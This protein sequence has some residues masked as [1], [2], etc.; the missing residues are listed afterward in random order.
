MVNPLLLLFALAN[1]GAPASPYGSVIVA[2]AR[3]LAL[4]RFVLM[5]Q[6]SILVILPAPPR[7]TPWLSPG[8]G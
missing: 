6:I 3:P 4:C 1:D 2:A 5:L 7:R 8:L